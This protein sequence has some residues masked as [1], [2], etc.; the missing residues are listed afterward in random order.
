MTIFF[1]GLVLVAVALTLAG[2]EPADRVPPAF[3]WLYGWEAK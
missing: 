3:V 1:R 2:D